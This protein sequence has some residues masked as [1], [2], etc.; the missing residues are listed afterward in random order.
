[1]VIFSWAQRFF[2]SQSE[3]VLTDRVRFRV[4]LR[5]VNFFVQINFPINIRRSMKGCQEKDTMKRFIIRNILSLII[6][7]IFTAGIIKDSIAA[8]TH[9]ICADI[10]PNFAVGISSF[11][12]AG[13]WPVVA[14]QQYG[15]NWRFMY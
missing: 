11:S 4:A 1:M 7:A 12:A 14:H 2:M 6:F 5:S 15:V 10:G 8:P 13:D 9:S 3:S